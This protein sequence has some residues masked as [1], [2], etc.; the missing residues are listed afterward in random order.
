M[1]RASQSVQCVLW[2]LTRVRCPDWAAASGSELGSGSSDDG[3]AA[4]GELALGAVDQWFAGDGDQ[5]FGDAEVVAP[6]LG[7]AGCQEHDS[8]Q[9]ITACC[10][11]VGGR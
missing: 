4:V 11:V 8:V 7:A 1:V 5:V 2:G 9:G 6:A 10:N 3:D